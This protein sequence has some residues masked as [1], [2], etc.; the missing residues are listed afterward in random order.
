[1]LAR[2]EPPELPCSQCGKP[3]TE[4]DTFECRL[5]CEECADSGDE[6]GLLPIT[7]SPRCGECGYSGEGDVWSFSLSKFIK[8]SAG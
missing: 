4:V 6:D 7:N 2:N 1:L 5:L 8:K 3:A